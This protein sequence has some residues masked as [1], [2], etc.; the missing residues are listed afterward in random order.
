MNFRASG[1][2]REFEHE[3]L[4][5][6]PLHSANTQMMLLPQDDQLVC[7]AVAQ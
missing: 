5:D 2:V 6:K 7:F 1:E 3:L 4:E